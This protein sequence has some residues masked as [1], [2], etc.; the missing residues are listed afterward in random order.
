MKKG[1]LLLEDGATFEGVLFGAQ[2][3]PVGEVVFNTGMTGYQEILTDPSYFGQMVVMTYPLIG[4]YG[5]N[6]QDLQSPVPLVRGF[7]IREGCDS[8]SNWRG[9]EGLESYFFRQG[10][11]GLMDVDTRALT[12][13]LRERG[14]LRGRMLPEGADPRAAMADILAF[15]NRRAVFEVTTPEAYKLSPTPC[16]VAVVDFGVKR[17]ILKSMVDRNMALTVY[18]ADVSAET[19]LKDKPDGVFLSNGPGDPALLTDAVDQ[20]RALL[21]KVPVFGIC[22]GHQILAHALGGDTR[23]MKF[24]HRGSNHPVRDLALERVFITSQNH[25]Y[26]VIEESLPADKVL[27][28]HVNVNDGTVEGLRHRELPAFSVQYHPEACPGPG[29]STYLFDRFLSMMHAF[30][31]KA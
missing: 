28:T 15:D 12:R 11:T 4:N 23:K 21:G 18:P 25:G 27:V 17:N 3:S 22:L 6:D 9:S 16:K 13:H 30:K 10:L 29:D 24:G 7:I 1:Y 20:V 8:F 26:E 2:G 14:T 31:E 19:I 5:F